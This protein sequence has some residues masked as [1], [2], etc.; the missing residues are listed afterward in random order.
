MRKVKKNIIRKK[1]NCSTID[2]WKVVGN[3]M[4]K[5][6]TG[7]E[8]IDENRIEIIDKQIICDKFINFFVGKVKCNAKNYVPKSWDDEKYPNCRVNPLTMEELNKAFQRL[9][10]KKSCGMDGLSGFFLKSLSHALKPSILLLFNKILTTGI[11]PKTWK[12]AKIVPVFK[13]R[14]HT[15]ISNYRPVFNLNSI[16]K[17]FEL[18]VLGR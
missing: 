18:C 1:V 7:V 9:S 17:L 15:L 14:N 10:G 8:I 11:Y 12:I 5:N 6:K 4:G 2:F 3:L 16:A 13:K